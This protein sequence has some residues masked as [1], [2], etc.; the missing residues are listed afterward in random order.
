MV[1]KSCSRSH[2]QPVPGVRSAAMISTRRAISGEGFIGHLV[3]VTWVSLYGGPVHEAITRRVRHPGRA[4][5]DFY[6]LLKLA[7]VVGACVLLGT[8]IGIA[9]FMWMANRSGEAGFIAATARIV[10]IADT[11]FTATACS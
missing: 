4:M 10:V 9:F 8:G 6:V 1:A 5:T 3:L 11:V 2:G 7:H